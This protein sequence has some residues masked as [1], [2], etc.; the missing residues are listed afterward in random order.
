M[1]P[2]PIFV[3]SVTLFK[4]FLSVVTIYVE[5]GQALNL[6]YHIFLMYAQ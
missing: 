6:V 5:S 3:T 1:T 2:S 4:L